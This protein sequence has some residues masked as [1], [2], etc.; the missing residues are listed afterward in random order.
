MKFGWLGACG[1]AVMMAA[2]PLRQGE[3]A[4]VTCAPVT[5]GAVEG[6]TA[7]GYDTTF[8]NDSE[9]VVNRQGTDGPGYFGHSDWDM[10]GREEDGG[11]S[12]EFDFAAYRLGGADMFMLV[13]KS[14]SKKQ[15]PSLIAYLVETLEGEWRTPFTNVPF[16][17]HPAEG[18]DV[19]HISYYVRTAGLPEPLPELPTTP[20]S[21]DIPEP[22]ALALFGLGLAGLAMARRK[23]GPNARNSQDRAGLAP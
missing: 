6:A 2:A 11:W 16:P 12:D 17:N 15:S 4:L 1:L 7:C 14:G 5:L 10:V 22:A 19:S 9:A 13:F 3:A 21:V 18:R 23:R 20:T 8:F